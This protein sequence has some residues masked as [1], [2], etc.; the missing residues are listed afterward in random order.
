M[1]YR[2]IWID[3]SQSDYQRIIWKFNSSEPLKDYR[4]LTLVYGL[5][6]SPFLALR[7]LQQLVTDEGNAFP[8]A[9][10]AIQNHCYVDDI[11]TGSSSNNSAI[12]LSDELILLFQRGGFAL[13]IW[14]SNDSELLNIFLPDYLAN[15]P[16]SFNSADVSCSSVN[17]LGLEWNQTNYVFFVLD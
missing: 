17:V 7:T 1:M 2:N 16:I 9:S 15:N 13:R 6:S 8:T 11:I 10:Y 3:K 5:T 12:K 14:S 4:L